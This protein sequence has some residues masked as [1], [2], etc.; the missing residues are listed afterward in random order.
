MGINPAIFQMH[1]LKRSSGYWAKQPP[2]EPFYGRRAK[3]A[4]DMVRL[5][6]RTDGFTKYAISTQPVFSLFFTFV[7]NAINL[8]CLSIFCVLLFHPFPPRDVSMDL[9]RRLW[10]GRDAV[11]LRRHN[12]ATVRSM[13]ISSFSS[14]VKNVL[15]RP[16]TLS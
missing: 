14:S 11:N 12:G 5:A 1:S 4:S 2:F 13:S 3:I 8:S 16:P 6:H 10:N 15:F 7:A 9:V